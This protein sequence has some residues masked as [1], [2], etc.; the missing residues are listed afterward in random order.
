MF[1]I[2]STTTSRSKENA[3]TDS[4]Q[5]KLQGAVPGLRPEE[6]PFLFGGLDLPGSE[7]FFDDG[8]AVEVFEDRFFVS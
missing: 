8:V 1:R 3:A 2:G 5:N 4:K 6:A 7:L